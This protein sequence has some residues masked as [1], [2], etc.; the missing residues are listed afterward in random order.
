MAYKI[1]WQ[2]ATH[3][4]VCLHLLACVCICLVPKHLII[5]NCIYE[6]ESINLNTIYNLCILIAVE[7]L[8]LGSGDRIGNLWSYACFL[9]L[10]QLLSII[11]LI[12]NENHFTIFK[13][14]ITIYDSVMLEVYL[15]LLLISSNWLFSHIICDSFSLSPGFFWMRISEESIC[16]SLKIR[17]WCI[18]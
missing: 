5:R 8:L 2:R 4:V 16:I 6:W 10:M 7:F 1:I 3:A 12:N 11:N 9:N 15:I 14:C 13:Y 17:C 18:W